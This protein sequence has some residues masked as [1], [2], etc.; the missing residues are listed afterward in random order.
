MRATRQIPE[1]LS[2]GHSRR[3]TT[4]SDQ[5]VGLQRISLP[6]FTLESGYS[7]DGD[8]HGNH[9]AHPAARW[10]AVTDSTSA[11]TGAGECPTDRHPAGRCSGNA[12]AGPKGITFHWRVSGVAEYHPE[13]PAGK[14]LVDVVQAVRRTP[15]RLR[16]AGR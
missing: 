16:R 1:R 8:I 5:A 11:A 7:N 10:S 3:Y 12:A 4:G 13:P 9:T 2:D 6:L 14:Y 15:A